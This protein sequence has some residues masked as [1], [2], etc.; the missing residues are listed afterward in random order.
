[1]RGGGTNMF[2]IIALN[3]LGIAFFVYMAYLIWEQHEGQVLSF[4]AASVCLLLGNSHRIKWFKASATG[5]EAETRNVI[6]EAK[7]TLA[8]LR[9]VAKHFSAMFVTM[10]Q[11]D[12]RMGGGLSDDTRE[13]MTSELLQNLRQIGL[14]ED[15]IEEVRLAERPFV[16]FDYAHHIRR[17]LG[18]RVSGEHRQ[19][20][21]EFVKGDLQKGI[22]FEPTPDE[23]EEFL[24]SVELL[25]DELLEHIEDYRFYSENSRHRRPDEWKRRMNWHRN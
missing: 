4:L 1:M 11:A 20:W 13:A 15:E 22:G 19:E 23:L 5:I 8:E 7:G 25:D 18:G 3:G 16:L 17:H 24:G 21:D 9:L 6:R 2:R 14:N 10:M 12:G